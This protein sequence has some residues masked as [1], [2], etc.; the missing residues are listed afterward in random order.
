MVDLVDRLRGLAMP[1]AEDAE[2]NLLAFSAQVRPIRR[3][4]AGC[5]G[6]TSCSGHPAHD[7]F[8]C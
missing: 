1:Y 3:K 4:F 2:G 6:T 7:K 8:K 5:S